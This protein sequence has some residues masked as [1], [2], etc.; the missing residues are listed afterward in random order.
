MKIMK[1]YNW[2]SFYLNKLSRYQ[3]SSSKNS[4]FKRCYLTQNG[5]LV[6]IYKPGTEEWGEI[7]GC[8]SSIHK[9]LDSNSVI[10]VGGIQYCINFGKEETIFLPHPLKN[11]YGYWGIQ[12]LPL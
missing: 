10:E 8:Y 11:D 6:I 2:D 5:H 12:F 9:E 1:F 3:V 7:Y 4:D